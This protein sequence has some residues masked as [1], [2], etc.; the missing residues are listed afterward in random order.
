MEP[1]FWKLVSVTLALAS[2]PS[3]LLLILWREGRESVEA[4]ACEFGGSACGSSASGVMSY[5]WFSSR[6]FVSASAVLPTSSAAIDGFT[7]AMA[8][9]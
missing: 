9:L 4:G 1:Y 3:L 6:G 5:T 2:W 8:V 7:S